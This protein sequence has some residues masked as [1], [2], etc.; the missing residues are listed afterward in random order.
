MEPVA[1]RRIK[2]H[3]GAP[4]IAA[5]L[6]VSAGSRQDVGNQRGRGRLA[7]GARHGDEG[8]LRSPCGALAREQ[9]DIADDLDTR[10]AG[11]LDRPVRLGMRQR[12]A[13]R[14]HERGETRPV[15]FAQIGNGNAF[16]LRARDA[17][18]IVVPRGDDSAALGKRPRGRDP[19][20]AQA[21]KGDLASIECGDRRH[22]LPQLERRQ[23]DQRQDDGD[24]PEPDD[25]LAFRPTELFEMVVDRRHQEHALAGQLEPGDLN[26]HRHDLDHE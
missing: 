25:H 7:V 20:S 21:E 18:G 16:S 15:D 6:C 14:Q 10:A 12:H 5:H 22:R 9:F 3:H 23:A 8:R 24:D 1:R 11:K 26:D 2:R 19:R 13:G 17:F 4:D